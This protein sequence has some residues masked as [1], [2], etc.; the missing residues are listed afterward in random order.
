MWRYNHGDSH[1]GLNTFLDSFSKH[2][3]LYPYLIPGRKDFTVMKVF[4]KLWEEDRV[5]KKKKSPRVILA[6]L[7]N[8]CRTRWGW[9]KHNEMLLGRFIPL[10]TWFELPALI[11]FFDRETNSIIFLFLHLVSQSRLQV[12]PLPPDSSVRGRHPCDLLTKST[13][14]PGSFPNFCW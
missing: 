2:I 12:I 11:G 9:R 14:K 3:C 4:P 1:S 7:T 13:A 8:K 10:T 6:W 5:N